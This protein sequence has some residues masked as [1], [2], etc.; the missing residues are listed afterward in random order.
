MR[1][2]TLALVSAAAISL[3]AC[4]Q[5]HDDDAANGGGD[6]Q[7]ATNSEVLGNGGAGSA[8]GGNG[9]ASATAMNG[10]S[11]A[12]T[13]AA[14]D[15]FEISSSQLARTSAHAPAVKSFANRMI[16]AH[17]AS[18]SQLKAAAAAAKPAITPNPAL[19]ADQQQMLDG[20]KGK[21]GADFDKAY[22]QAQVAGHQATLDAL[23]NYSANGDVPQ[24]K[25]LATKMIP[26]VTAHLNMAKGLKP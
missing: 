13:A 12:N 7:G 14:S 19:S 20:L 23:R 2:F 18:T 17:T 22:V 11:F 9:T 5:K 16:E 25:A 3:A 10:Q 15:A 26:T 4:G 8:S 6:D 24:L 1:H 21:T